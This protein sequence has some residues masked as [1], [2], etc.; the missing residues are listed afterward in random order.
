MPDLDWNE[1]Y[2][3]REYEWPQHGEEWSR[4]WGNSMV[5]WWGTI[6]PRISMLLPASRVVEIAPGQGRWTRY[7]LNMC[8]DYA[9]FDISSNTVRYCNNNLASFGKARSRRFA[10]NSGIDLP[11]VEDGSADLVF[12]FDSL[13]H[14]EMTVIRAYLTE[15]ARVLRPGGHAF[16]HHSNLGMFGIKGEQNPHCRGETVS[17]ESVRNVCAELGLDVVIQEMVNW[18]TE[19]CQ[20]CFT[21]VKAPDGSP[22]ET[23][24]IYNDHFWDEAARTRKA[25]GAY[26][27]RPR[28][29]ESKTAAAEPDK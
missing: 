7:L 26:H 18:S 2:W 11:G 20:D 6:F 5:Q 8:D 27:K 28:N 10:I 1:N 9:G 24:V 12:S 25:L 21:T 29:A 19:I 3:N 16:I 15:I 22:V 13:V 14:V 17:A 4:Q 23:T